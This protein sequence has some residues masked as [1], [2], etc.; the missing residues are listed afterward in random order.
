MTRIEQAMSRKTTYLEQSMSRKTTRL[1]QLMSPREAVKAIEQRMCE[2]MKA[3]PRTA[4]EEIAVNIKTP[5][6]EVKTIEVR[7][8]DRALAAR[9]NILQ[10]A[11][12]IVSVYD[13]VTP[14]VISDS[15]DTA[16]DLYVEVSKRI[17]VKQQ[18][19]ATQEA[20]AKTAAGAA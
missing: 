1:E 17:K 7:D 19:A 10:A 5:A 16:I 15:V 12:S 4:E 9:T 18:P 13:E 11:A 8:A 14:K 20:Q 2:A 6:P 3:V